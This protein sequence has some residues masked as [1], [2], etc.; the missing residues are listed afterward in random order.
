MCS[1]DL[2]YRTRGIS[3][4]AFCMIHASRG[5]NELRHQLV[6]GSEARFLFGMALR[7]D[8]LRTDWTFPLLDLLHQAVGYPRLTQGVPSA[9]NFGGIV[10]AFFGFS[11]SMISRCSLHRGD[12]LTGEI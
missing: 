7:S 1:S 5:F 6:V 11:A 12:N 3:Q 8:R 2:T 9:W 10:Y 4:N